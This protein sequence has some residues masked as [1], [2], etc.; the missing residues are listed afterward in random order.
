MLG[1][2]I[3]VSRYALK[4]QKFITIQR[5]VRKYL[6]VIVKNYKKKKKGPTAGVR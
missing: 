3:S 2:S 6:S 4:R 1:L 5:L